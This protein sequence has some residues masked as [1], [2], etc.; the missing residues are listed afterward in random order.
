MY[1]MLHARG[2][3]FFGGLVWKGLF[4]GGSGTKGFCGYIYEIVVACDKVEEGRGGQGL[5]F[6]SKVGGRL[7]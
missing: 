5:T 6:G 1:M 4:V 2:D 3:A 7:A